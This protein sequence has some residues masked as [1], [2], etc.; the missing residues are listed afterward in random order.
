VKWIAT[1]T[2]TYLTD[3]LG[4]GHETHGKMALDEDGNILGL[5]VDTKANIGAYLSTFGPAI[6]TYFYA[7]LLSGQY[8]IPAIHAEVTGAFTNVPPVDAYR[9]A[10]RPEAS[11]LIE[12]LVRVA[13]DEMD[14]DPAGF[15][16]QNFVPAEAFPYETPVAMT[17]DSGEYE[18][19]LDRA[20]ELLDYEAFRERQAQAREEGRYLGV[21]LSAYVEACGAAPS[22]IA[23]QLGAQAGL[24]ESSLVRF[25]PS[26][27]VSVYVGTSGHGQ[28]HDTTFAQIVANEL[29]VDYDDVEIVEGDTNEIP[30]GMGTY[31]SRSAAVGGSAIVKSTQKVVEKGKAIAAHQLE[32]SEDDI[33]FEDGEFHVA[34]APDRAMHITDVAEASYL[35]HDLPEGM[36]PGLEATS[37]YDPD[38]FVFPFGMHAAVVEVDPDTGEIEFEN[39]VAVDDVGPQINPKI[40]EGQIHGGIAQGIGQ[41]LYEEAEFDDNGQLLTGSMQDYVVPKADHVPH[42]ETDSTVTESPHNP[43]GVKGVGEAGTIA[44][45]QAVVNAVCDALEP[46]DVDHIDMPLKNEKVWRAIHENGGES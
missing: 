37:F 29:G 13:A 33:E 30:Q 46:F 40:V 38:N 32:A 1:R 10:G 34:G 42:I 8:E 39:Y 27:T 18:K 31:G 43:L 16:R 44:A 41:A 24:W 26:G 21:G 9:G 4:R 12:R 25:Q 14:M 45:P 20:L 36:E 17:Y 35:A 5:S 15:R 3:A 22:E 19:T 23:G 28:G 2:E 7:P 11:Y 6:P